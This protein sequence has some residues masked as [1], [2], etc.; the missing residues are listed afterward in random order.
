[1]RAGPLAVRTLGEGDDAVVL[2]HGLTGSGDGFGG[3]FGVLASASQLVIPDL[4]GFGASMDV[5]RTDF[6]LE[7]HLS[8]LD[9]MLAALDLDDAPLTV[10]GHSMG[11]VLALHWA[12]S[13]S[14]T[15][16]VVAFCGPLYTSHEEAARHIRRMGLLERLFALERPL[17]ERTCALMC[18]YRS[19]AQWM[20]VAISP[21]WPVRLARQGVLHTWPSYLGG[22]NGI[23]QRAGWLQALEVLESAQVPVIFADGAYDLVP[24]PERSLR[25]AERFRCVEAIQ[26]PAAGHELPVAYPDWCIRLIDPAVASVRSAASQNL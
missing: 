6:S 24:V 20:A 2:L 1:M 14:T 9:E 4:L 16:R 8:A 17:A 15:R 22:M 7:A 18:E 10:V 19:L 25:L 3:G 12:S 26:H 13:R 11:A 5:D 23:M 21:E